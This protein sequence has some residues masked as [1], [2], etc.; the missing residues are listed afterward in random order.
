MT[1]RTLGI[2]GSSRTQGNTARLVGSILDGARKAGSTIHCLNLADY[3]IQPCRG[4]PCY[5][6]SPKLPC[7]IT[8]DLYSVGEQMAR[9]DLII[10]S[11]PIYWYGP[12]GLF[13]TFLDRWV[14]LPQSVFEDTHIASALT[15]Q[16][17]TSDTAQPT[18]D[19]LR[20]AFQG[21]WVTYKG[22]TLASGLH[23][24]PDAIENRPEFLRDGF[25]FGKAL[26]E[27]IARNR[28]KSTDKDDL[29]T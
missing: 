17:A 7:I 14:A 26:C 5:V 8:D 22:F 15:M 4:C 10:V 16:D 13:K 27:D 11:T 24:A 28:S 23:H 29:H 2:V 18:I 1:V 6:Q 21:S 25:E 12:S 9:A 3:D 19:M 20:R